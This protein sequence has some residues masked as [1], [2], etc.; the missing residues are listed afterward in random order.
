M[1][2]M[3]LIGALILICLGV[4]WSPTLRQSGMRALI[5]SSLV[6]IRYLAN[7]GNYTEAV[8]HLD[9]LQAAVAN[10]TSEETTAIVQMRSN[11]LA[12]MGKPTDPQ[13]R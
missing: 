10:K 6:H 13:R 11:L 12:K 5:A 1:K 8:Q 2:A 3:K 4:C 7:A 9:R